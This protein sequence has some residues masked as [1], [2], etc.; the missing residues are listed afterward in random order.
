LAGYKLEENKKVRNDASY[1]K[2]YLLGRY[3]A[4]PLLKEFTIRSEG[5]GSDDFFKIKRAI[6]SKEK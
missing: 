6:E 5:M 2:E 1:N 3:G 4:I